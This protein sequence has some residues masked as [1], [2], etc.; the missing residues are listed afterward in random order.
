MSNGTRTGVSADEVAAHGR[1]PGN[2][3]L[4]WLLAQARPVHTLV[5]GLLVVMNGY[6]WPLVPG[7]I[8]RQVLD[9]LTGGKLPG[10]DG[11]GAWSVPSLLWLLV[12]LAV[13]RSIGNV[14][15]NVVEPALLEAASMQ[16]RRNALARILERPGARALPASPGEAVSRFRNDVQ[17]VGLFLTWTLDPVGQALVFVAG[18][19]VLLR[20]DAGLTLLVFVPLLA[21]FALTNLARTRIKLYRQAN[22]Q[23]IG[24][25]TGLLGELYGAVV[26]VKS[27]GAETRVVDHL[28]TVNERRRR[29]G[30]R[31][32][33]LTQFIDGANQHAGNIGTGLLL[34]GGAAA[35][36]R[37]R[38]TVGDFALFVSYLPWL[39]QSASWVG[40]FLAKLRRMGVSMER[41]QALMQGA[42]PERLVQD[43]PLYF[44]HGPPPPAGLAHDGGAHDGGMRLE[45]LEARG[46]RFRYPGS[47]RGIEA[48]DLNL[49]RGSFTV[50]T[51]RVGAG[52]TTLLRVLLG[53][54]PRDSGAI[55]WNGKEVADAGTFLVPPRAAYTP[56]VPRLFS[57]SLQDNILMGLSA[58]HGRLE[59]ALHGA[60]LERDVAA[61]PRGLETPVGPRGVRLSGG[62]LQRAAAARMLVREPELLVLDDLSSALDVETE[63]ALWERLVVGPSP[64]R[65]Q[66]GNPALPQRERG[67]R[68]P[69]ILAVS[70][71]REALRRADQIVVLK[72]GRVVDRGTLEELLGRCEEMRRLWTGETEPDE[73]PGAPPATQAGNVP[74]GMP[75]QSR[76][77]RPSR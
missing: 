65:P 3:R 31:D 28:R 69:T 37:G 52:K 73:V 29:A 6:L 36:Q 44:R 50:V 25:V 20:I 57:E 48:V 27:A 72:D 53:L 35:M 66:A 47:E 11:T 77:A 32:A 16:L 70:H 60:V 61:L 17:E 58:Q 40:E 22:Q 18:L 9:T 2:L 5:S 71:R 21:V 14:A 23:A 59:R 55:I 33:V 24:E 7:L 54:L 4:M 19:A 67:V 39:A 49:P 15:G 38:F 62:Q 1:S 76:D 45:H 41:L 56:Q 12:V 51:G 74:A 75:A 43:T 46:L 63:R 8:V 34:L 64:R 10:Q 42:P 13:V 68:C 30:V 26:A